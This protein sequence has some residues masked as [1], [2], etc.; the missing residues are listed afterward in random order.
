MKETIVALMILLACLTL[1]GCEPSFADPGWVEAGKTPT[2]QPFYKMH[3]DK[4]HVTYYAS[5]S[6]G[7]NFIIS[8][9]RD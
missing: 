6:Y 5:R 3:D 9:V 4:E 2:G 8:V 7:S 1:T